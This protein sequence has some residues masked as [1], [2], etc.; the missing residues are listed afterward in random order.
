EH[1]VTPVE[2]QD[3]FTVML[4]CLCMREDEIIQTAGLKALSEDQ[5]EEIIRQYKASPHLPRY[6]R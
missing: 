6:L 2:K 3:V 1:Y 5:A 4:L